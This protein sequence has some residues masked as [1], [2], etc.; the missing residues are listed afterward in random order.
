MPFD[1]IKIQLKLRKLQRNREKILAAFQDRF[2]DAVEKGRSSEV[3][4]GLRQD[5]RFALD[6]WEPKL[7]Y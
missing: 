4:G 6:E 5:E 7:M 2:A 1:Q 3:K